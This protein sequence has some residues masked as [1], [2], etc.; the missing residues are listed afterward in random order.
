LNDRKSVAE[1]IGE[2]LREAAV[3]AP[4]FIPM[5]RIVSQEKTFNWRW[6]WTTVGISV[7]LGSSGVTL[8]LLRGSGKQQS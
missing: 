3:L 7:I 4:V 6:F 8:E 2:I 1:M 5:D